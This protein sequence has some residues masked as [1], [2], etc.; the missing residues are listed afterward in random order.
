VIL[1]FASASSGQSGTARI[2]TMIAGE[3]TIINRD[4]AVIHRARGRLMD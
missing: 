4:H 2:E 1:A 3:K